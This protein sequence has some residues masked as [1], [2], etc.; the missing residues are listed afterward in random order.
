MTEQAKI[1]AKIKEALQDPDLTMRQFLT[2]LY[3]A[4]DFVTG[5]DLEKT[6]GLSSRYIRF[7]K[8]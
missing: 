5:S 8:D 3:E 7:H 4:N 6:A 2:A 1:R